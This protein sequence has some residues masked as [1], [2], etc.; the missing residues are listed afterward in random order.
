MYFLLDPF[1]ALFTHVDG[2]V[3]LEVAVNLGSLTFIHSLGKHLV[4]FLDHGVIELS[5]VH[6]EVHS[7]KS[8]RKE[9]VLLR[10]GFCIHHLTLKRLQS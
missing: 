7:V 6:D 4:F 5:T 9:I 1:L 10:I 2:Q 3:V 8:G